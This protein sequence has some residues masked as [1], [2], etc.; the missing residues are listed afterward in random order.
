MVLVSIRVSRIRSCLPAAAAVGPAHEYSTVF[1][2]LAAARM[3]ALTRSRPLCY[4]P[5]SQRW[6]MLATTISGGEFLPKESKIWQEKRYLW[7]FYPIAFTLSQH[8]CL[9][10]GVSPEQCWECDLMI[11]LPGD[12]QLQ[13]LAPALTQTWPRWMKWDRN[14][15]VR[16]KYFYV[17]FISFYGLYF[18]NPKYWAS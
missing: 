5:L 9:G 17:R 10:V 11:T 14:I 15:F 8:Q 16:W 1:I 7:R 18:R 4:R 2:S 3:H 13:F 6:A 12:C